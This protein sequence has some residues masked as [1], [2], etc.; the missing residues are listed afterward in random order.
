MS[1]YRKQ[2]P[3]PFTPRVE[4]IASTR[5]WGQTLIFAQLA[6]LV[7]GAVAYVDCAPSQAVKEA[8]AESVY[9]TEHLRCVDKFETRE[10]IDACRSDVRRRWGIAET[11][12]DA[13]R[14]R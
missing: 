11:I 14:D 1:P 13:G 8:A 12:T 6:A 4:R 7:A 10:A 2:P 3:R 5:E 9:L